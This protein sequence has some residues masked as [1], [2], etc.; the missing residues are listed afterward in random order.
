M[1]SLHMYVTCYWVKEF[2]SITTRGRYGCLPHGNTCTRLRGKDRSP[3]HPLRMEQRGDAE[4]AINTLYYFLIPANEHPYVLYLARL[5][6]MGREGIQ[7]QGVSEG[8][9]LRYCTPPADRP[10]DVEDSFE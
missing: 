7:G 5:S 3:P 8:G 10:W 4:K 2:V 1:A 6:P 9:Y